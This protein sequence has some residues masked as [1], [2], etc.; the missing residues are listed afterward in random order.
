MSDVE[1][2]IGPE[3]DEEIAE[4]E[5]PEEPETDGEEPEAQAEPEPEP[6]SPERLD[7][8]LTLDEAATKVQASWKTYENAIERNMGSAAKEW[9]GCPM[10]AQSMIPGHLRR[11]MWGN[12]PDEIAD[13]VKLVLGIARAQEYRS[14]PSAHTCET[15][16]GHGKTATGS[17]VG[18]HMTRVCPNCRGYGYMPPPGAQP[19]PVRVSDQGTTNAVEHVVAPLPSDRDDWGEPRTLPDG[20]LNDNFGKLPQY[21]TVHPVFGI[22][23]DLTA[24]DNLAAGV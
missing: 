4:A 17:K 8:G 9:H 16:D 11:E 1:T 2:E 13:N 14:D 6:P 23:R 3:T 24:Q 22:T 7:S 18:E 12:F 15:C 20:T 5:E 21:K 10:C 19:D